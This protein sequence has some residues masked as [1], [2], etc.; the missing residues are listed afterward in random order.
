MR[1]AVE[2]A[3]LV[4]LEGYTVFH[5]GLFHTLTLLVGLSV[6]HLVGVKLGPQTH[7]LG[8]GLTAGLVLHHSENLFVRTTYGVS[9]RIVAG[10]ELFGNVLRYI[11]VEVLRLDSVTEGVGVREQESG[12]VPV[13]WFD[14]SVV[15]IIHQGLGK[16]QNGLSE[17]DGLVQAHLG[18]SHI[19]GDQ[20]RVLEDERS[21]VVRFCDEPFQ[22]FSLLAVHYLD[23]RPPPH[24][25]HGLA[26]DAAVHQ[27]E[28]VFPK[29]ISG[30]FGTPCC[31]QC[32]F[33]GT[34]SRCI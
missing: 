21:P 29:L 32:I 8:D 12:S 16:V 26:E 31:W 33:S 27:L 14:V 3:V 9:L 22:F 6:V 11:L 10:V 15:K 17:G 19:N 1:H 20:V 2:K 13:F 30:P 7:K 4:I 34:C 23:V 5:H 18:L 28:E 24:V 25:L